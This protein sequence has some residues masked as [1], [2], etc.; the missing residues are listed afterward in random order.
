MRFI[1]EGAQRTRV[2]LEHRNLERHGDGWQGMR[3]AV[4]SP[5]GWAIG[6][7]RFAARVAS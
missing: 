1:A 7:G 5:D 4:G 6:L 2:E 3:D